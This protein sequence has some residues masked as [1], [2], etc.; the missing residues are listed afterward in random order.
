MKQ[1]IVHG[2]LMVSGEP[3]GAV[4]LTST[5]LTGGLRVYLLAF[6]ARIDRHFKHGWKGRYNLLG[7][8]PENMRS[9]LY[10]IERWLDHRAWPN[11]LR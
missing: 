8:Q 10:N 1:Y 7:V 2:Y 6:L 5:S 9:P 3:W 4:E 11:N